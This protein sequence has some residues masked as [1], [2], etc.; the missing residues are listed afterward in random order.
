MVM[1]VIVSNRPL[2]I[3]M[4]STADWDNPFWTNKQHVALQLAELGHRV[5][6][7]ESQGLRAPTATARDMGRIMRRLKN[8][9]RPPRKVHQN[10]HVW[11]PLV[12]PLQGNSLIRR[13]NRTLLRNG[14]R[15]CKALLRHRADLV[16]TYSPLTT[17][18]Y[19]IKEATPIVY[20]AVDAIDAQP[21]MPAATIQAAEGELATRANLIF[22]TAHEIQDRLKVLNPATFYFSNVADYKH[23]SQAMSAEQ[24]IPDELVLLPGPK[25]IFVGAIA[26]Y[27]LNTKLLAHVAEREAGWS[28]ILI[29]DVGEGDPR[30][31]VPEL[32]GRPNIHLLGPRSYESLPAFL[33]ASDVAIIPAP[34]NRYTASMFPMKFF[35]YLAAGLPVVS[36]RLPAL[37][38]YYDIARFA[39][40][41]DD[42]HALLKDA[43]AH[44]D[45]DLPARLAAAREQTYE[46]R[47]RKMMDLVYTHT[48]KAVG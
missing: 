18:L 22:T 1:S 6:Y 39:D 8:G 21:G 44:P 31:S 41:P 24:K 9:L 25:I 30:T 47:T 16:W 13:L 43:I 28:F 26:S 15:A 29:G 5:L 7:I 27:K 4:I 32:F 33:S 34:H 46:A 48:E 37:R 20:H 40:D 45:D 12:V 36:T 3:V 2:D 17:R 23:F 35:E 19:D 11:S 38:D 14:L 10:I 42:F